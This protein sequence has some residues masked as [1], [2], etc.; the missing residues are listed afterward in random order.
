MKRNRIILITVILILIF[1]SVAVYVSA[2]D[3]VC[4]YTT[5]PA[6]CSSYIVNREECE[7]FGIVLNSGFQEGN[8]YNNMP[9]YDSNKNKAHDLCPDLDGV[10]TS[11]S[12]YNSNEAGCITNTYCNY[13]RDNNRC[14][15]NCL[16]CPNKHY[17]SNPADRICDAGT[18]AAQCSSYATQSQC[19]SDDCRWCISDQECG[20]DCLECS[21][22]EIDL[23]DDKICDQRNTTLSGYIKPVGE[24][25]YMSTLSLDRLPSGRYTYIVGDTY[26]PNGVFYSVSAPVGTY[27]TTMSK[28]GYYP[29]TSGLF[30]LVEG[31][32]KQVNFTLQKR[33]DFCY[34]IWPNSSMTANPLKCVLGMNITWDN[35]CN[36]YANEYILYRNNQIIYRGR[37]LN[38]VDNGVAWNTNYSYKIKVLFNNGVENSTN[39]TAGPGNLQCNNVCSSGWFCFND[40]TRGRCDE[41]NIFSS[42][43]CTG[44]CWSRNGECKTYDNCEATGLP[45]NILGMFYYKFLENQAGHCYGTT[46]NPRFCYY[47]YSETTVDK[48]YDCGLDMTCYDYKSR[49]ACLRDSCS[50][51]ETRC[52]FTEQ[53]PYY[54]LG[55]GLCYD[56][57]YE[58]AERCSLCSSSSYDLF[59]SSGCSPAVCDLLGSCYPDQNQES[60]L[61]CRVPKN[62]R[63][64]DD[65]FWYNQSPTA[66]TDYSDEYSCENGQEIDIDGEGNITLSKDL[67]DLGA[68]KWLNGACRKDGNDDNVPDCNDYGE[69]TQNRVNCEKDSVP[70]VTTINLETKRSYV[71]YNGYELFVN[72]TDYGSG[73]F[74]IYYCVDQANS[75]YPYIKAVN[76]KILLNGQ[77]AGLINING[78]SY[79]RYSSNDSYSNK[80]N[81]RT[82]TLDV[83]DTIKPD[84]V[85]N[86]SFDENND[87]VTANLRFRISVNEHVRCNDSLVKY[88]MVPETRSRLNNNEIF[89]DRI[90]DY[91]NIGYGYYRYR[92]YCIDD[93]NNTNMAEIDNLELKRRLI[94]GRYPVGEHYSEQQIANGV[95]IGFKTSVLMSYNCTYSNGTHRVNFSLPTPSGED[96]VYSAMIPDSQI[97]SPGLY[98]Y[99]IRCYDSYG[100]LADWNT[101]GFIYDTQAPETLL[102]YSEEKDPDWPDDYIQLVDQ[103]LVYGNIT[104]ALHC[105]DA[106]FGLPEKEPNCNRINYC[107]WKNSLHCDP[108]TN[109]TNG[110]VYTYA[111]WRD[112]SGVYYINAYSTDLV[113]ISNGVHGYNVTVDVEG[114]GGT[115]Y[116]E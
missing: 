60:C 97:P 72:A 57:G 16:D 50:V 116:I 109:A 55:K 32:I 39:K 52:N 36:D 65:G 74:G 6:S 18:G 49:E 87:G 114:P 91:N 21:D 33:G 93:Y 59:S 17:D 98:N 9:C 56:E 44:F 80:E 37:A 83:V 61:A 13:C 11:C 38:Y 54:E 10:D 86:Y 70:P 90:V 96:N 23:N 79:L 115:I 106:N 69:G 43:I 26:N 7:V 100:V 82:E 104:I 64:L 76:N 81:V 53:V 31:Q 1:L 58:G 2:D 62:L 51:A 5:D 22:E 73:S 40:T 45:Q 3:M 103:S 89:D 112:G 67:C 48:C 27:T 47:D 30:S 71:N 66:C 28:D 34:N 107:I 101:V 4:C 24:M 41:K 75:C 63:H 88:G 14:V 85:V 113:G 95:G 42:E 102:Y 46:T 20:V 108:T 25:L 94:Y 99:T 110:D 92:V 84:I 77:I 68:C 105:N 15:S 78:T 35:Y 29:N 12:D 19:R 111:L 8:R